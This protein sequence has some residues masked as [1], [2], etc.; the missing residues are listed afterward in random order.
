MSQ[1][2]NQSLIFLFTFCVHPRYMA[3]KRPRYS[4][5]LP[6]GGVFGYRVSEM[7]RETH[8][9]SI[10]FCVSLRITFCNATPLAGSLIDCRSVGCHR[11]NRYSGSFNHFLHLSRL[12]LSWLLEKGTEL[13]K[14]LS[15]SVFAV[16]HH[17]LI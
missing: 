1:Q 14:H 10:M 17:R 12:V 15:A 5:E 9:A 7:C 4:R 6:G 13:T 16:R 3:K 8:R 11:W 2:K